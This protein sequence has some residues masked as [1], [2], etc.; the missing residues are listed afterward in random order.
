MFLKLYLQQN[1]LQ[2]T[3]ELKINSIIPYST[4]VASYSY[5]QKHVKIN[6]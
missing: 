6:K 4:F 1:I 3:V 2:I 5:W